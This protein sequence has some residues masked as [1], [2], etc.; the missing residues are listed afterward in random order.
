VPPALADEAAQERPGDAGGRRA[1]KAGKASKAG[2]AAAQPAKA[3]AKAKSK[4]GAAG[5]AD[6]ASRWAAKLAA[7]KPGAA[8]GQEEGLEEPEEAEGGEQEA[9]EEAA[10]ALP[11]LVLRPGLTLRQLAALLG[12]GTGELEALLA[13]LGEA[14]RSEVR[15]ACTPAR[16]LAHGAALPPPGSD[17]LP[18]RLHCTAP[19]HSLHHHHHH[20]HH[21]HRRR[22]RTLCRWTPR[23]WQRSSTGEL[24]CAPRRRAPQSRARPWSR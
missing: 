1:K 8:A 22:R 2:K 15:A 16:L 23:S 12:V 9:E 18:A 13:T 21:H 4:A 24:R 3:P 11:E 7:V 17:R 14:L 5:G 10:A 20:H 19:H 6:L